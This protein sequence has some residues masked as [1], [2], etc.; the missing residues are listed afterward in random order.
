[1]ND[2]YQ[3]PNEMLENDSQADFPRNVSGRC[4]LMDDEYMRV[5][6]NFQ[7]WCEG[8]L[9]TGV[10]LAG[11][12]ANCF[13]IGILATKEMRKHSFN[14]LLIALCVFDLL[15]IIVSI[16]VYS[17]NLFEIFVGNQVTFSEC[18]QRGHIM[19]RDL[20]TQI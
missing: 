16:P 6:Y 13:S 3:I 9:F 14:Q 7:W 5:W 10:G 15:F 4:G 1:M 17:F 2:S 11:L 19:L 8:V 18:K 20:L 12:L